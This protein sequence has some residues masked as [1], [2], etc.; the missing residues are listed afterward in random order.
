MYISSFWC[1]FISFDIR[2]MVVTSALRSAFIG[3]EFSSLFYLLDHL[4]KYQYIWLNDKFESIKFS[5]RIQ[6]IQ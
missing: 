3:S 1:C 2:T 6:G 5:V 4:T